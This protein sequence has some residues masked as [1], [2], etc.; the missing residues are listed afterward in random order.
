MK[1][2]S[3]NTLNALMRGMDKIE[4]RI[5]ALIIILGTILRLYHLD[6]ESVWLDEAYSISLSKAGTVGQVWDNAIAEMFPPLHFF[7]L[8]FLHAIGDSEFLMRLPSAVAGILTIPLLY[9]AGERFFGKN[10]GLVAA[11]LL[12]VSPMHLFYSQEARPYALVTLL[13][14]ASLYYFYIALTDGKRRDWAL[15]ILFSALAFYTH[16]YVVFVFVA[17]GLYFIV[18]KAL[19]L[20]RKGL[21]LLKEDKS[22]LIFAGSMVLLLVLL[23]PLLIPFLDQAASRTSSAPGWGMQQSLG[24]VPEIMG[25]FNIS[26]GSIVFYLF[27]VLLFLGLVAAFIRQRNIAILLAIFL[28]VP[29]SASYTLAAIM[30]FHPRYILFLLPVYLL[31]ISRGAAGVA[32]FI[33]PKERNKDNRNNQLAV[34]SLFILLFAVLSYTPLQNYYSTPQKEDWRSAGKYLASAEMPQGSALIML[35]SYIER[36]LR[37]YYD[38]GTYGTIVTSPSE[39]NANG[40]DDVTKRSKDNSILFIMTWDINAADHSGSVIRW[41]GANTNVMTAFNGIY[42]FKPKKWR[43]AAH[44]LETTAGQGDL[45][46]EIP[47]NSLLQGYYNRSVIPL[48]GY[49]TAGLVRIAS[50]AGGKKVWYVFSPDFTQDNQQQEAVLGWLSKNAAPAYQDNEGIYIFQAAAK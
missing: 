41:L 44:Y 7:I 37:Y 32:G 50:G 45:V 24:M 21:G 29:V 9:F 16:Y 42:I 38:N 20:Q 17:E 12:A 31:V 25:Q 34:V 47:G 18:I 15:F 5:L 23:S 22:I 40:M 10:E 33:F 1:T 11:F 49:S 46:V 2:D 27:A 3:S 43:E 8:Y 19:E 48:G 4:L 35:P 26:T 36:P 28:I 30:P 6:F 13:A 39:Y 14:L